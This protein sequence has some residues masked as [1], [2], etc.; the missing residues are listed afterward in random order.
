MQLV[1]LALC[2]SSA[3]HGKAGS[4]QLLTADVQPEEGLQKVAG[5]LLAFGLTWNFMSH[6]RGNLCTS[7]SSSV[8]MTM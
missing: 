6:S 7:R 3:A 5:T 4:L 1:E 2:W 8:A